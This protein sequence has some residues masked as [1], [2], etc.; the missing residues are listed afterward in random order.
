MW[1]DSSSCVDSTPS[2]RSA[3]LEIN[4]QEEDNGAHY[5]S[6]PRSVEFMLDCQNGGVTFGPLIKRHKWKGFCHFELLPAGYK[7]TCDSNS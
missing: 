5:L 4:S 2:T 6:S 7:C 3:L 1:A